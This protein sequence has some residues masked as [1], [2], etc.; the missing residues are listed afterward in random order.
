[1]PAR[2]GGPRPGEDATLLLRPEKTLV[3]PLS[4]PGGG[5]PATVQDVIYVGDVSRMIVRLQEG[6][7]ITVKQSNRAGLFRAQPG[8]E[9]RVGW[10]REDAVLL[11]A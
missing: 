6:P 3:A 7:E 11:A 4:H 9:V 8:M 1:M 2:D 10:A 5:L